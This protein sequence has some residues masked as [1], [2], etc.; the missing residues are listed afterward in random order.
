[1]KNNGLEDDPDDLTLGHPRQAV[2]GQAA[3][4]IRRQ[5]VLDREK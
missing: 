5:D 3:S 2:R 1:M 4:A